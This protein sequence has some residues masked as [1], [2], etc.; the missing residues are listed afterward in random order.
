MDKQSEQ[1]QA[2]L[3]RSGEK[4]VDQ[5]KSMVQNPVAGR[6]GS[7]AVAAQKNRS[8]SRQ[9]V[10]ATQKSFQIFF[11]ITDQQPVQAATPALNAAKAAAPPVASPAR[12]AA[13]MTKPTAPNQAR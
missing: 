11:V 13:P 10:V 8:Q 5:G 3:D 12:Q 9:E 1:G 2:D 6:A 7:R 4:S